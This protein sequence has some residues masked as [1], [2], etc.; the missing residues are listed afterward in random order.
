[1]CVANDGQREPGAAQLVLDRLGELGHRDAGHDERRRR[2]HR[3]LDRVDRAT[4]RLELL[5]GLDPA[6]LVHEPR[7]GLQPVGAE[8]PGEVERRL[9]PDP[10]ADRELARACCGAGD[11][12]EDGEAVVGL[13]HDEDLAV[14]LLAE[15]ERR[16]HPRQHE[17][18][19]RAGPEEGARDPTVCVERLAE[20]RHG[21]LDSGQI[22]EVGRG[23]EEERG[24]ALGLEALP[25]PAPAGCVVEHRAS[26]GSAARW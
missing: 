17:H 6:Q 4:H 7:A 22:L 11:A 21:P 12:L 10:V 25:E 9:G 24:D 20:A 14:G 19:L 26:L 8:D 13:V 2:G 15:I 3:L 23:A 1:M 18:R 5:G 16:E